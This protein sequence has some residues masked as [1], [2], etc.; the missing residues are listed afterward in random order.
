MNDKDAVLLLRETGT[1]LAMLG[2]SRVLIDAHLL[3]F[4]Q[5]KELR[6]KEAKPKE[7]SP[8]SASTIPRKVQGILRLMGLKLEEE[9]PADQTDAVKVGLRVIARALELLKGKQES[10]G[11]QWLID[12]GVRDFINDEGRRPRLH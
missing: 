2:A 9:P 10:R 3:G 11:P 7:W 12:I 8:R 5:W 1:A 4:N 6:R